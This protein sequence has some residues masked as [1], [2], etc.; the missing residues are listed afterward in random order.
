MAGITLGAN[1]ASLAAQRGLSD[2]TSEVTQAYT[3]LSSG[4]RINKASDD[5]AGLSISAAL[6]A[7][8]KIF[9][10]AIRNINDAVSATSISPN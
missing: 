5:A 4:M 1:I 3:R 9:T 10:Q 6:N 8:A 7:S 2:A